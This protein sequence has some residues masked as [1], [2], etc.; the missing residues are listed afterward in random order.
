MSH[1]VLRRCGRMLTAA[2]VTLLAIT[3]FAADA[4]TIKPAPA[5]STKELT[6]LPTTNW[7]TNGGNYA[8]QRFSPLNQINR[9]NVAK[10]KGVWRA[11]L[12]GSALELRHNN[13]AQPLIYDGVLYIS[14]GQDDVFA[15]SIDSGEVLW[16]YKSGLKESDALVCCGWVSRGVGIG[17]GKVYIGQLDS[18]LIA[19]DQKT[20]K[21][22]WSKKLAEPKLGY[23]LTAAPLYYD[24]MVIIGNAGGDMGTR[25]RMQAFNAKNGELIWTFYT[26]PGPGEFGHETWPQDKNVWEWGGAPIWHTPAVDPE[27]GLLYFSTGNAGP[28]IGGGV[29]PGDNLFTASIV[30]L[31]IKTGKYKWH[32][33]EVH[34]DIWDYDAPN[35]IILFDAKYNGVMRKGL[36]QAGKT[37]FVYILDRLTGE[38]LVGIDEKPVMQEPK[39]ATAKT[40]PFPRGD[41][42]VPLDIPYAPENMELINKGAIFTPF[43]EKPVVFTP[44]A[45][46][47][48]P[49]S[50]YDP[51]T[52]LMFICATDT[53]NAARTDATQYEKPTFDQQFLGGA[54]V[55]GGLL[56]RGIYSAVDLKT[57]KIVWQKQ[58]NEGCRSGSLATA[59]G[60]VFMGRNDGR[61]VAL[62]AR[63][64]E[65]LWE[66]RTDAPIN[67]S[68]STFMY[69]GKQYVATYAGGGLFGAQKGD[70]VWLF[71]LDGTLNSLPATSA[72]GPNP[73]PTMR[74][75]EAA[76]A[77][78]ATPP[79]GR[80]ADK[81]NGKK[82]YMAIC[83]YCHG[84]SGT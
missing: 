34:H 33:Q 73:N 78:V 83:V 39:Q 68:V 57:N 13:Q 67:S 77:K 37:G 18:K 14:T 26:I 82:T 6:E 19:L 29:R 79:Q 53:A 41:A 69:K 10:L 22:L 2:I 64:G 38:P 58:F 49:P 17:D 43:A 28:V 32:F 5:F 4:P 81:V 20:G 42:L 75:P 63:N 30:A 40:Q 45:A 25:G 48:W 46:V 16:E 44:M 36:A 60:L 51:S 24:G 12:K 55:G 80:V 56:R 50:A 66:F 7:P 84:E 52:N 62:D 54:Y 8:N 74:G 21:L 70:G 59:G 27:A 3:A 65:R 35:P 47:N 76:A 61:L 31:D 72:A 15:V 11:G 23:S 71:S 1:I 9:D